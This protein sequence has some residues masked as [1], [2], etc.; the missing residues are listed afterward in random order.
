M[1]SL[2]ENNKYRFL[3]G[4][5]IASNC[6]TTA[7]MTYYLINIGLSDHS[8]GIVIAASFLASTILSP[9][10]GRVADKSNFFKPKTIVIIFTVIQLILSLILLFFENKWTTA[11]TYFF[12]A[13]NI[14]IVIPIV[15]AMSFKYKKYNIEINFGIARG[16]GSLFFAITSFLLGYLTEVFNSSTIPIA[17]ITINILVLIFAIKVMPSEKVFELKKLNKPKPHFNLYGVFNFIKKYPIF[18]VILLGITLLMLFHT[19]VLMYMIRIVEKVGCNANDMGLL[20]G[21]A[22]LTEIPAMFLYVRLRKYFKDT[23]LL[24]VSAFSFVIKAVLL[25]IAQDIVIVYIAQ[26]FQMTSYGLMANAR[27]YF[28]EEVI[29]KQDSVTGQSLTC[30]CDTVSSILGSYIGGYLLTASG[31]IDSTLIVG[32]V[33]ASIGTLVIILAVYHRLK[34]S[35]K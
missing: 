12:L 26:M 10:F 20:I 27:V 14:N 4:F 6:I 16:F 15:Y 5:V 32:L 23:T 19:I 31:T 9:V 7:Y 22:A 24:I 2:K 8:A 17:S 18:F 33:S 34:N 1:N 30:V 25:C 35:V 11:I 28:T 21:V 29:E 13:L 3:V